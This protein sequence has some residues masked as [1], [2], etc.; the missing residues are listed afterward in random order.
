MMSPTPFRLGLILA[1]VCAASASAQ[2]LI[3]YVN[4]RDAEVTGAT[5][6]FDGQA[7][8]VGS[9]SVTAKDHT[10]PISLGRGG[11]VRVCQSTELHVTE[12]RAVS[13]AAPLLFSLD[14]GAIEIQTA[15]T[16]N[17]AIMTPDLRFTVRSQGPLDLRLRVARNGDTCVDNR[18]PSAPTLAVSDP[19]GES[20]YEL[21]P[22]QH[23][24]FEHG[25]LREVVDRETSPCGCPEPKGKS[26]AD[27]LVA[28]PS[29]KTG[30]KSAVPAPAPPEQQHPF[31]VAVSE[32]LAPPEDVPPPPARILR[33]PKPWST[34]LPPAS[35][36]TPTRCRRRTSRTA[37][38][39]HRP[40][41]LLR[42]SANPARR[43]ARR[44][45]CPLPRLCRRPRRAR[46][47]NP[48]S[49]PPL[50]PRSRRPRTWC[51]SSAACS[52]SCS[53]TTSR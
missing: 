6:G 29:A 16:P 1:L 9:V 28:P 38:S 49:P 48:R 25:S 43:P 30:P 14:R 23:V 12:N 15:G 51:T 50:P 21:A 5:D 7:V 52:T 42:P 46:S 26:I 2:Q 20:M 4:T 19:F 27:A 24:L 47:P 34:S 45:R 17:D 32:G 40:L 37:R 31:P 11:T 36:R 13:V 35:S 8:L 39:N 22:D 53:Y 3:G 10:A 18:G 41:P 44:P 33:S